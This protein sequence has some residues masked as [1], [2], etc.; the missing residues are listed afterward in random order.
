VGSMA[1]RRN[2]AAGSTFYIKESSTSNTGW[3]A[4]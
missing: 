1:L 2:G 3:A 4:K